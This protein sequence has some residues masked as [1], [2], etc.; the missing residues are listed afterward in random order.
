M[1][2]F[3]LV[4]EGEDIYSDSKSFAQPLEHARLRARIGGGDENSVVT[5]PRPGAL[6]PAALVDRR[7]DTAGRADRGLDHGDRRTGRA[8]LAHELRDRGEIVLRTR[9]D[10]RVVGQHVAVAV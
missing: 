7:R 1:G 5:G 9:R 10:L 3:W 8:H 2:V 6:A 4:E